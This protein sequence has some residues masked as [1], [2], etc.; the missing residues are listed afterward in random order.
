MPMDP[1]AILHAL[2]RAE[3]LR[4]APKTPP[5]T[6]RAAPNPNPSAKAKPTPSSASASASE[7]VP[8][9]NRERD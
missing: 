8:F 7:P 6:G 3:S 4:N 1:Y 2:V 5:E 9:R